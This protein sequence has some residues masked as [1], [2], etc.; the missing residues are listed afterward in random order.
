[1]TTGFAGSNGR[2]LEKSHIRS[3]L[4]K[5]KHELP[6]DPLGCHSIRREN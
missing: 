5:V 3:D 1:M 2:E 6:V 4:G